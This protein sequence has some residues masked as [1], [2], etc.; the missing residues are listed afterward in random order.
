[1]VA[2]RISAGSLEVVAEAPR[3]V[4]SSSSDRCE[5]L[6][7]AQDRGP[8]PGVL[9]LAPPESVAKPHRQRGMGLPLGVAMDSRKGNQRLA[10]ARILQ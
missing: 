4:P 6:L 8:P 10:R 5:G 2:I 7:Q 1:M 9:Y 3:L